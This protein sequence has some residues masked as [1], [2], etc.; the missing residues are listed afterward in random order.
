MNIV[1]QQIGSHLARFLTRPRPSYEQFS[2]LTREQLDQSLAPGDLLLIEGNS[3]VSTATSTNR[4]PAET[5]SILVMSFTADPFPV[6]RRMGS[7]APKGNPDTGRQ[8]LWHLSRLAPEP[9]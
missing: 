2:I 9:P 7:A 1:L 4:I 5:N 6:R 8:A 3:R